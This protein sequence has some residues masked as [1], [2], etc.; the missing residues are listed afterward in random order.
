MG[1]PRQRGSLSG[2]KKP[3]VSDCRSFLEV[4]SGLGQPDRVVFGLWQ[5]AFSRLA[6]SGVVDIP[7]TTAGERG[8]PV[9]FF[10][11]SAHPHQ[12]GSL[13]GTKKPAVTDCRSFLEVSSG[14]EPLYKLLQSL[15]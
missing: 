2:T 15:A 14:F 6:C 3:A 13:S 4:S 11:P 5:T 8:S 10:V 9:R 7:K 1:H 12:R